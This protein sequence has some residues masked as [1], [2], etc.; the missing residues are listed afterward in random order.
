MPKSVLDAASE[1]LVQLERSAAEIRQDYSLDQPETCA[2]PPKEEN[3]LSF[4]SAELPNPVA[5]RLK[6][7]NLMEIT[8]SQA[9]QILEELQNAVK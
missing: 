8:P 6:S 9:F 7:L 5:D 1:K 2:E 4:F 3:Q